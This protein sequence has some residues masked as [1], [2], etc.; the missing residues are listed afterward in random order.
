MKLSDLRAAL[1]REGVS[2]AAR[3][4]WWAV[5]VHADQ[6]GVA[7]TKREVLARMAGVSTRHVSTLLRELVAVGMLEV[8][9]PTKQRNRYR[10]LTPSTGTPVQQSTGTPVQGHRNPSSA[11]WGSDQLSEQHKRP[12]FEHNFEHNLEHEPEPS[13]LAPS[14]AAGSGELRDVID[15]PK[16]CGSCSSGWLYTNDGTVTRCPI[17]DPTPPDRRY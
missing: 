7:W 9:R 2:P 6:A 8:E 14:F 17:C 13:L 4:V 3:A 16:Y 5:W 11:G 12:R 10:I 1:D 15:T